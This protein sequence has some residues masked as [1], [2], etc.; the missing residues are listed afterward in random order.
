[1]KLSDTAAARSTYE[2]LAPVYDVFSADFGHERWLDAI[3][4]VARDHG[5]AGGRALDVACGT[6][7]SFA[8]LVDRGLE[9]SACDLSPPSVPRAAG[10]PDQPRRVFACDMQ[11]LPAV[12]PF[13]LVT[14]LD[15]AVNYL[16]DDAGLLGAFRSVARVLAPD[17]LFVFD[18]NTALTYATA[19]RSDDVFAAG[20][21]AFAWSGLGAAAGSADR[22]EAALRVTTADG[23]RISVVHRQ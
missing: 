19:F 23:A 15:D 20:G 13:D 21:H 11:A 16:L 18:A 9:V 7:H 3:H 1:M 22:H 17:G 12:G 5:L 14:C 2:T 10:R 4:A 6:G 8:P